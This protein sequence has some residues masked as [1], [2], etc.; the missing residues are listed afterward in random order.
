M[1]SLANTVVL[2][3]GAAEKATDAGDATLVAVT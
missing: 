3:D 2:L 1:V